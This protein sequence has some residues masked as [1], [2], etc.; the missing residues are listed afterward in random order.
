LKSWQGTWTD[1]YS[2]GAVLYRC[3]TG[4][5]PLHSLERFKKDF[6]LQA[7]HLNPNVPDYVSNSISKAMIVKSDQ[8]FQSLGVFMLYLNNEVLKTKVN[9]KAN[10]LIEKFK[11]IFDTKLFFTSMGITIVVIGI[12]GYFAFTS[13]FAPQLDAFFNNEETSSE[14]VSIT[15]VEGIMPNLVGATIDAV[16]LDKTIQKNYRI[17][18]VYEYNENYAKGVVFDQFPA[19]D[20]TI[21][22]NAT[23]T[24]KV[25]RGSEYVLVPEIIGMNIDKAL[26]AVIN[27]GIPDYSVQEVDQNVYVPENV[28]DF[29]GPDGNLQVTVSVVMVPKDPVVTPGIVL[30]VFPDV[31][32]KVSIRTGKVHI[33]CQAKNP[34]PPPVPPSSDM[35]SSDGVSSVPSLVPE[36]SSDLTSTD[37]T[38]SQ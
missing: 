10:P 13:I 12:I 33:T 36:S 5:R 7:D 15:T 26:E 3:L 29:V 21:E 6:L 8:R 18:E 27:A 24:V 19:P 9:K 32:Q 16:K 23:I 17:E 14:T 25:S 1:V 11:S 31:G 20:S 34:T 4:T 38:S 37:I 22:E 30:S 28:I 2:I 35:T